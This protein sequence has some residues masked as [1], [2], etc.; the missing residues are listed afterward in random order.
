MT[1]TLIGS[2]NM[3]WFIAG[4]M[5]RAG[6]ACVGQWGRNRAESDALCRQYSLRRL[7][8]ISEVHDG[9][10]AC[11]LAV[12]DSSIGEVASKLSFRHTTL[13]HTAGSQPLAILETHSHH[14]GVLWPVYSIRKDD[15]PT[16]RHFPVLIEAGDS[17]AME[18]LRELAKA[19]SDVSY[20]VSGEQR[21]WLHLSAVIGNNFV[22]HL[23]DIIS[24]IFKEQ[25]LP[26]HL[27][28]P[29]LEQT[30]NRVNLIDPHAAQTGPARRHDEQTLE[31]Q[32]QLLA[33][34]LEWQKIYDVMSAAIKEAFPKGA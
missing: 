13:I 2:G 31:M 15:L 8:D 27:I 21:Q 7:N 32:H 18:V 26:R 33:G 22:N 20:E 1:Y 12:S 16:H 14:A 17:I 4:Q 5:L 25:R 11:I 10:E 34:H 3:A 24:S 29:L 28:Q 9:P 6:H 23:L 19:I 30:L